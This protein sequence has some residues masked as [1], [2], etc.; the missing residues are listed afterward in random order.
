MRAA[1][2]GKHAAGQKGKKHFEDALKEIKNARC[3]LQNGKPAE[4]PGALSKAIDALA[5]VTETTGDRNGSVRIG[6]EYE[7]AQVIN[8]QGIRI[9]ELERITG[10]GKQTS[11]VLRLGGQ[12]IFGFWDWT[13]TQVIVP[14]DQLLIGKRR[15]IGA[16]FVALPSF[17]TGPESIAKAISLAM[18]EAE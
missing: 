18:Q 3:F 14:V 1:D 9:G 13:G 10:S 4:A 5:A 2:T 8:A 16:A 11:A 6:A 15:T 17:E 12:D 7:G